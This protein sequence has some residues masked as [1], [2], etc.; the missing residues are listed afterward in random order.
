MSI[1][2]QSLGFTGDPQIM[3]ICVLIS[4]TCVM[5]MFSMI[6]VMALALFK[7]RSENYDLKAQIAGLKKELGWT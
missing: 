6:V 2:P 3:F 4:F 5:I 1:L 7:A